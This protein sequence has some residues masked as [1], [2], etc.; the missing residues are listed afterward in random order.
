MGIYIGFLDGRYEGPNDSLWVYNSSAMFDKDGT[1]L[2]YDKMQLLPFGESIPYA[3]R[4]P[5]LS[6]LDF[7]QAN[8]HPG[9]E[10]SPLRSRIGAIGPMIC[11]ESLFPR[12]A[13][14]HTAGG[15]EVLFNITNDGWFG[16]SPGPYQHNEMA[17]LRAV[18]NHRYLVRS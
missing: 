3:W 1:F 8:F 10:R 4:F 5:T 9:P 14:K 13:R 17:I 6:K 16:I 18:E 12:I 15:A 11:F 2:Q 7:G